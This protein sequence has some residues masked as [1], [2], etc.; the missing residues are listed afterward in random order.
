MSD[1]PYDRDPAKTP[2]PQFVRAVPDGDTIERDVCRNCGFIAYDNPKIVVGAVV[3]AGDRI[4]LCRRAIPP[5]HGFWTLP[6]GF[7]ELNETPED[8]ARREAMEEANAAIA[9]ER[10]LAIYTIP[11]ISQVQ[12]IFRARL[13]SAVSPGPE[14]LDVALFD[15]ADIPWDEIAFPSVHWALGHERALR[16]GTGE[17]PFANPPGNAG[18]EVPQR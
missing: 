18:D 13:E 8:G 9:I 14:S 4:L 12:L 16:E 10:L 5:R 11:R 2:S 15:W 6:A 1:T 17:A 7:M 3:S